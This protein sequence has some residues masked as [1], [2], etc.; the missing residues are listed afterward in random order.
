MSIIRICVVDPEPRPNCSDDVLVFQVP[1]HSRQEELL[2]QM[3]DE[4]GL[5]Y[6]SIE[7]KPRKKRRKRSPKKGG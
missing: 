1:E 5:E 7:P 3:L 6:V 2:K 4:F